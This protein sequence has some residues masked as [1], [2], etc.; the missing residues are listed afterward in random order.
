MLDLLLALC[1]VSS[2]IGSGAVEGDLKA[3]ELVASNVLLSGS[4]LHR[5][6]EP[7]ERLHAVQYF[8]GY[9]ET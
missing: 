4:L 9:R 8:P 7:S 5:M 6:Q 1:S 2:G 3:F